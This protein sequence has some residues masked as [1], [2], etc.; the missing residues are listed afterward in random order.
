MSPTTAQCASLPRTPESYISTTLCGPTSLRAFG[1]NSPPGR[2]TPA[3][4]LGHMMREGYA[5][6]HIA[7]GP[8]LTRSTL[9]EFIT[10]HPT[11]DYLISTAGHLMALRD[12][13]LT[14]TDTVATGRRRVRLAYRITRKEPMEGT[15]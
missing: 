14:D 9:A 6:Q 11:G 7:T 5:Y 3:V 13:R 1:V 12:G 2:M 10:D 8:D 4:A 15:P